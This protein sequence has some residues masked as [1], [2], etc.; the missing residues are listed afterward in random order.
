MSMRHNM[1]FF[2]LGLGCFSKKKGSHLP[3][4]FLVTCTY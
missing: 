4:N 2:F 3:L 1:D